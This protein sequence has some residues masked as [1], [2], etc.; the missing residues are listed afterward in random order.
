LI[1]F[2]VILLGFRYIRKPSFE[3]SGALLII[4]FYSLVLFFKNYDSELAY[5][6]KQIAL[7]GRYLFPVTGLIYVLVT[8]ASSNVKSKF[9]KYFTLALILMLFF[10]GGPIKFISKIDLIFLDW[11]V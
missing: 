3:I 7:Q 5:G 1:F 10:F 6:F 2:W 8:F 11:F 4:L 9:L